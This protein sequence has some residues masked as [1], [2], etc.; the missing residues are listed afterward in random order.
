MKKYIIIGL[1]AI[2][3][4]L[5]MT[6]C[7]NIQTQNTNKKEIIST[8]S[9]NFVE[10][11][12]SIEI[13][14]KEIIEELTSDKYEGRLVGS[15][16]NKLAE[17]YLYLKFEELNL[18]PVLN[19]N[20]YHKYEQEV[21][22]TYGVVDENNK[23]RI[24]SVNNVVGKIEGKNNK[25]A[26]VVSAHFD[27]IGKQNGE[28]IRGAVDNASG[29]AVLL[30]L[31]LRLKDKNLE[32]D[33]IFC[34]FNG[35]EKGLSG[36]QKFVE[37]IKKEYENIININIDSVGY[38]NGGDIIFLQQ[39]NYE[40]IYSLMKE[41]LNLNDIKVNKYGKLKGVSDNKNFERNGIPNICLI[42]ENVKEVIHSVKDTEDKVDYKKLDNLVNSVDYF[43]KNYKF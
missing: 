22:D 26:I 19:N 6:G 23:T 2:G 15:K 36:S 25:N 13:N 18:K 7:N 35:E 31:A 4:L 43:I 12:E 17:E 27:H 37:D 28:I 32:S 8:D 34:A 9:N 41:S 21:S 30:D 39:K 3:S 38:K 10:S 11:K 16:G 14:K 1:V 33:I 20:L 5:P 24:E 29:V 42:D 40:K